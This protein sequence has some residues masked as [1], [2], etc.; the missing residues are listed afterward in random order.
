MIIKKVQ[1]MDNYNNLS[2]EELIAL[3]TKQNKL[4][5]D[6]NKE[7]AD[8][9]KELASKNKELASKNKELASKNEELV[10]SK[11]YLASQEKLLSIKH[12]VLEKLQVENRNL[13]LRIEEL[14]AKYEDKLLSSKKFQVEQFIPKSE[15]LTEQDLIIN[16]L[17]VINEKKARKAPTENFINDLKKL[18]DKEEVIDYDFKN[19]D[20][21]NIKPFGQDESYKIEYKPAKFEVVKIVRK[22]YKDKDKIYQEL[23]DD[24]F[25]HSSLTPS[26]AANLIEMKFNLGV[27]FHRYSNYL[28]SHGLNISDVNIYNYAKRTMDLL[29]PL[30]SELL[31]N[32]LHNE[33]NVIHAD[34]TPL[35]VIGSNKDKCYMFVY[36]TSFWEKPI[37]IYDFNDSRSTKNL[38]EL[39]SDYKGYLVCD[40]YTGYDSLTKQGITIQRCMVHARRYFNDVLKVL[41]EKDKVKS[42]AHKVLNLMSKL[43]KYEDGFKKKSLTA[44]QIVKQR[45]SSAYQ[46]IIKELDTY[47]D[48]IS[49]ENNELLYKAV[50]YYNNN[51]K[52]L[53][54]YLDYGYLDISNNLAE[55]VVKPFV[56][57]RKSFLFCKTADGATTTGKLFSIVQTAR[58][59]GLK[60]EEYLTYVI[61]NINKKD[62]ND[63]LPW[64]NKLPK[65]LLI[66]R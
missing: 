36:T 17:E 55:R 45:K 29:E 15:K 64:S 60:S 50:K 12:A 53:Y 57:A 38:K 42:P 27:P 66:N 43:F 7:L 46:S 16:E 30:Y 24:P 23:S 13:N 58:A 40:G 11:K 44:S 28:I 4:I 19:M 18:C 48:S 2:K 39:L 52:E 6:A 10:R 14:I 25:P 61:S 34:E 59:N 54:T 56:I 32:L 62:I 49:I 8:T 21:S 26:L 65:E 31:N 47:I 35:K 33:F 3:I 41:D 37:Y 20:I 9:N 22:K 63:L 1:S 5:D 51:K